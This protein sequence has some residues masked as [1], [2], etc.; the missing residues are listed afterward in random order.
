MSRTIVELII[1][2]N[3]K[4]I[5]RV[6]GWAILSRSNAQFLLLVREEGGGEKK[7]LQNIPIKT[8]SVNFFEKGE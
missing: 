1:F 5:M 2:M 3:S 7:E 6:A 4:R 8:S